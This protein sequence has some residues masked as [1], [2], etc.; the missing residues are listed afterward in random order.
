MNEVVI[1]KTKKNNENT[2]EKKNKK[3]S[4]KANKKDKKDNKN[5]VDILE[6]DLF[7]FTNDYNNNNIEIMQNDT[8]DD[9]KDDNISELNAD[10][11]DIKKMI[12]NSSYLMSRKI[13]IIETKITDMCNLI[14][15]TMSFWST[16]V[17]E[18]KD[19][20]K[21]IDTRLIQIERDIRIM[22]NKKCTLNEDNNSLKSIYNT[23]AKLESQGKK[24]SEGI[25]ESSSNNNLMNKLTD[26][27]NQLTQ[28]NK[29]LKNLLNK[30]NINFDDNYDFYK[31][32]NNIDY[33]NDNGYYIN[34]PHNNLSNDGFKESSEKMKENDLIKTDITNKLLE[35]S[36]QNEEL[37]LT[38]TLNRI[39]SFQS[40]NKI[41]SLN[42]LVDYQNIDN[43]NKLVVYDKKKI[44]NN[45]LQQQQQQINYY[46][47][48]KEEI[49]Y[50]PDNFVKKCLEHNNISGEVALFKKMYIENVPKEYLPIRHI[51][52]KFQYWLNDRM[53]DDDLSATY[54]KTTL[55]K[56]IQSLYLKINTIEMYENNMDQF[57]SNQEYINKTYEEK[58]KEKFIQ[59]I[60][61][62]INI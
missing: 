17:R 15:K 54:I 10:E 40:M 35:S 57:L 56:N 19:E 24:N 21:N 16:S 58:Y 39:A 23:F 41:S 62:F 18:L 11:K 1:E 59:Q 61:P 2:L 8:K 9:I 36:I 31:Q 45:N 47:C 38:P 20:Q 30:N 6:S 34:S 7:N 32:S 60:I 29:N 12:N 27:I 28:Q 52:K 22:K 33:D 44:L 25:K 5:N 42:N 13:K 49:F 50:L 14:N 51:R 3:S 48:V 43:D 55:I 26:E 53:N 46:R 37:E 4:T